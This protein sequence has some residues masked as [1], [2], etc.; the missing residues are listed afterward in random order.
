[1]IEH[2]AFSKVL[3]VIKYVHNAIR[4][5]NVEEKIKKKSALDLLVKGKDREPLKTS[6]VQQGMW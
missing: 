1:M 6:F 3:E 2:E 4:I 5:I